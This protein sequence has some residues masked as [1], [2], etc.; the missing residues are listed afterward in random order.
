MRNLGSIYITF[1]NDPLKAIEFYKKAFELNN[2]EAAWD[3]GYL[4]LR[5]EDGIN[6]NEELAFEWMLKGAKNFYKPAEFEVSMM[7][8]DGVG[9]QADELESTIWLVKAYNNSISIHD[10]EWDDL[11]RKELTRRY[12]YGIGIEK[13]LE[14]AKEVDLFHSIELLG[15]CSLNPCSV[16]DYVMMANSYQYELEDTNKALVWWEKAA[17]KGSIFSQRWLGLLYSIYAES[18]GI[19]ANFTKAE[20]WFQKAIENGDVESMTY[21][22]EMYF[23][24]DENPGVFNTKYDP[25]KAFDL[26]IKAKEAGSTSYHMT[27]VYLYRFGIG[28][29]KNL[30]KALLIIDDKLSNLA[31]QEK[32]YW[33]R[34]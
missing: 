16:D 3:L 15:D 31:E 17:D 13:S 11:V 24:P 32:H 7:Y 20:Y 23:S 10:A 19:K 30:Q 6:V 28:V 9:V 12:F 21:L 29:E 14:K 22:A 4:Y 33:Y 5:G 34:T 2:K 8:L 26:L 25:S 18:A 1:L 27:L